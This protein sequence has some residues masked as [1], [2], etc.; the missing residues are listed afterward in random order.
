MLE[1]LV[2]GFAH[3]EYR[4]LEEFNVGVAWCE[5]ADPLVRNRVQAAAE[6][7]PRH[8]VIAFPFPEKTQAAF[9]REVAESHRG[10]F[11]ERAEFYGE[12]VRTKLER[13]VHVTDAA[14]EAAQRE[15]DLYR[16]QA[17]A[18]LE[19]LDLLLTPT[20]TSIAPPADADDLEIREAVIRL[21]YPFNALG[22]PALAL[23]CGAAERGLPASLQIVGPR[24]HDSAVLAAAQLLEHAL[25]SPPSGG[26]ARTPS[27]GPLAGVDSGLCESRRRE[28][29]PECVRVHEVKRVA[30]VNGSE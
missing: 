30:N 7:F 2:P 10:L 21:T 16:D 9:M 20:L 17:A 12:N 1:A 11:P 23:P 19:G 27:E 25:G 24:G 26:P 3:R 29:G 18:A 6:L 14:F 28:A 4:S 13:C 22:W 8:R 5:F 15:R